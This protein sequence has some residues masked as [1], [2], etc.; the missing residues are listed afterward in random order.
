L[1]IAIDAHAVEAKLADNESFAIHLIEA[2]AQLDSANQ[3]TVYISDI[4]T[5]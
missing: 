1:P 3:Y 2:L 4:I 5:V